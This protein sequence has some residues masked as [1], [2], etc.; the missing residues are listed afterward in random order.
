MKKL[1]LSFAALLIVA[2]LS[3]QG[4]ELGLKAGLNF[5]NQKF[6]GSGFSISPDARTGFHGGAFLTL[7]LTDNFAIQ[8]EALFSIQGSTFDVGS[9]GEYKNNLNYLNIPILLRYNPIDLFN[10]HVGPQVGLLLS[11]QGEF[12]GT[13]ESIKDDFNSSD[14]GLAFGAG[15]DLPF[16]LAGGLRYTMGLS[17]VAEGTSSGESVKNNVFQIYVG[18]KLVS[19]KK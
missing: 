11:A 10:I 5:A 15:I 6:E 3:A 4:V 13:K 7:F 12:N 16:G 14:I 1:L 18:Y 19:L 8:P 9:L 2:S 17:N